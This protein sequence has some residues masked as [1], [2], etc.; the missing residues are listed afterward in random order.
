M[1]GESCIKKAYEFIFNSDFEQAIYW[2]EQ[3]IEAEPDNAFYY[4][5]CAVSCARSGKWPKA[6]RYAETALALDEANPE[7]KYH[8][9]LIEAKLL[10]SDADFLLA[11]VPPKL[12][13]AAVLLEQAVQ[14]DPLS[15]E[16]FY[17]L[18]VLYASQQLYEK[19]AFNAREAVRLDPGHSAAKRLFA[20]VNR[21]R[22]MLRI[23]IHA[24]KR[25]RNR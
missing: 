25:K 9:Q 16:A 1:D 14:L 6:K 3:A 20:D 17:T 2:F 8:L 10:L 4:H 22:R 24:T 15:F 7:Y 13:E 23:R 18:G 5:T 11:K 19:A 12:A 21:K